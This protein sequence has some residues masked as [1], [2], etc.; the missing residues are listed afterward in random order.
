MENYSKTHETMPA[1]RQESSWE[2][3]AV[4]FKFVNYSKQI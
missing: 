4:K 2:F 1:G 3:P